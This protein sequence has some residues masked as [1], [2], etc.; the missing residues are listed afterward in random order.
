MIIYIAIYGTCGYAYLHRFAVS[1]TKIFAPYVAYFGNS[2][3]LTYRHFSEKK[4]LKNGVRAYKKSA[5]TKRRIKIRGST[6]IDKV[7]SH[8][9]I[10][11]LHCNGWLRSSLLNSVPYSKGHFTYTSNKHPFSLEMLS[12]KIRYMLLSFFA[13]FPTNL[14]GYIFSYYITLIYKMQLFFENIFNQYLVKR[15]LCPINYFI[16]QSFFKIVEMV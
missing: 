5:S 15:L 3:R 4:T 10:M 12:L 7:P 6:L 1:F 8:S 9:T 14:V 16:L 2:L 13:V 11:L